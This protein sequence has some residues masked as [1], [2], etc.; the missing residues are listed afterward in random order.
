MRRTNLSAQRKT[1]CS[2]GVAGCVGA[3]MMSGDEDVVGLVHQSEVVRPL[4]EGVLRRRRGAR[5]QPGVPEGRV[6][7]AS[8][9]HFEAVAQEVEAELRG[10]A[11]GDVAAVQRVPLLIGHGH[12]DD[13]DGQSQGV[14]DRPHR[15]GVA[16]GQVV[17]DGGDVDALALQ[18]VEISRQ[19]G[20]QGLAF[21]RCQ[22]GEAALVH[23]DAGRQLHVERP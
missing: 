18:G 5:P 2:S 19:R 8:A 20:A 11:V 21:A 13:A 3:A 10:R 1:I 12:L 6:L 9:G 16:T 23:D 17:I 14:V 22:F 4:H 15:L 7:T